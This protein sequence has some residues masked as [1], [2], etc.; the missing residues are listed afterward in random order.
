M[1]LHFPPFR[2]DVNN[3]QLWNEQREVPLRRKTFAILR[4]LAEHAGQ[5]V[6]KEELLQ[7]VWGETLVSEEGLRDYLREIRQALGDDAGAPQFV[8]TVRGRGY[9]FIAAV[10][11]DQP[12]SNSKL[13][14][15]S[16]TSSPVPSPQPLV[17]GE[18]LPLPSKPSIIVLP[19]FNLSNDPEQDYFSDGITEDITNFL[20]RLSSLFVI[21]R[22]SAFTYK[23]KA[24]KVQEISREMGVR[25]VLEGSVRKTNQ[26]IRVTVQLIDALT[27][28]HLWSERYDR[29][30]ADIFAV[31]DEI[32]QKIVTALK[33]QLT[34]EEQ[35]RFQRAPTNN[36][37]AYDYY[38]RGR[39][40]FWRTTQEGNTQARQLF[41]HALT[42]DPHYAAAY[43]YLSW[44][45]YREWYFRWSPDP[46]N[47]EQAAVQAQRAV[48]LDDS[49]P[50]AHRA[51]ALALWQQHPEQAIAEA[52][53]AIIL[54]PNDGDLYFTLAYVLQMND[55]PEDAIEVMKKALRLAPQAPAQYVAQLGISYYWADRFAEAITIE[56]QALLQDPQSY[57]A[58]IVLAASYYYTWVWQLSADPDTLEQAW[59]TAQKALALNDAHFASHSMLSELYLARGQLEQARAEAERAV[60]RSPKSGDSYDILAMVLN[61]TGK[62]EEAI[63]V[64]EHALRLGS[65][66]TPRLWLLYEL[67]QAYGLSGRYEEAI[68]TLT[69][70]SRAYPHKLRAHVALAAVY[71]ELGK[72]AEARAEAT[73]VLRINPQWSLEVHK[74]R[75]PIKDPAVL[76]RHIAALRRAG[77][78]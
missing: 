1:E 30:L 8:E 37:E 66:G 59:A 28:H 50:T 15:S 33:V 42:L 12:A 75:V 32:V 35:Q 29:P 9:R 34:P 40:A 76:E 47:V 74:E 71:G 36:L 39:E 46:Q 49:L 23:G 68:A 2:L 21:S 56:Q 18:A 31:Q 69:K 3:E 63:G 17:P 41:E 25:Y 16:S 38:L 73:E 48:A 77:L 62:P 64:A 10:S 45:S 19:F 11:T 52:E 53:R 22:T 55:R 6:T 26:Q 7:A 5:L 24:V 43:A 44:T 58:A 78:R 60:A 67:G 4:Y 51:L 13:Q 65:L 20:S 57:G 54:D 27:D 72:G 61:A 70:L 14:V